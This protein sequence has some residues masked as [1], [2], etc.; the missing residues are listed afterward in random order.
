MNILVLDCKEYNIQFRLICM[1]DK[2]CP[3]RGW[4]ESIGMA[5]AI[6][7]LY[8]GGNSSET[9]EVATLLSHKDAIRRILSILVEQKAVKSPDELAAVAHRVVHGGEHFMSST[10]VDDKI[11][12]YIR[13]LEPVAPLHNPA[14]VE[15]ILAAREVLPD[16]PQ[17]AHFDTAFYAGMPDYAYVYGLPYE[18]YKRLGIRRYGF[19]GLSHRHLMFRAAHLLGRKYDE[20]KLVSCHLGS[21]CSITAVDKGIVQDTTMGFTPVEGLVMKTR[22][23]DIDPGLIPFLQSKERLTVDEMQNLLNKFSGL[24]GLS[25]GTGRMTDVLEAAGK[26]DERSKIALDVFC[27]RARKYIAAMLGVIG[28]ADALVFSAGIGQNSPLV[29]SRCVEGLDF[30]GVQVD[31]EKNEKAKGI[32]VDISAPDS[33]IK[34]FVIPDNEELSMAYR[35]RDILEDAK[36]ETEEYD[37]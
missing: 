24:K 31:P 30:L 33:K 20:I 27:Y 3:V 23:G 22:S 18:L 34:V 12:D 2:S 11:I 26:G 17:V 25:G 37:F 15:G 9:Q 19:H 21:G 28:G 8:S 16:V 14:E 35:T 4:V 13:Q 29:R 32:E 6:I 1:E 10:L 5:G 7:H 36:P